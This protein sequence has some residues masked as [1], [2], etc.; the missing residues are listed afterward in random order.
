M[1]FFISMPMRG[2]THEQIRQ[3]WKEIKNKIENTYEDAE[4]ID[5]IIKPK[6]N[7]ELNPLYCLGTSISML[8]SADAI[9]LAD[10]WGQSRGCA[11]ERQC[12]VRYDILIIDESDLVSGVINEGAE[13]YVSNDQSVW[14]RR[15]FYRMDGDDYCTY[16]NGKTKFT[17][18]PKDII[19]RWNYCLLN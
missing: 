15:I 1:R 19:E 14:F 12:A 4:V 8:A 16:A 18:D 3:R 10:G 5:S 11:I 2:L 7:M 9:V 6:G 17:R 13:V